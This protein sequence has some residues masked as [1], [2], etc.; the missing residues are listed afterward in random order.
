MVRFFLLK[1]LE[2]A[3]FL[4]ILLIIF[5]IMQLILV[6]FCNIFFFF[7]ILITDQ[8]KLSIFFEIRSF[9]KEKSLITGIRL[10]LF[11]IFFA[12][13]NTILINNGRSFWFTSILY[14]VGVLI[15]QVYTPIAFLFFIK[16]TFWFESLTF[17]ILLDNFVFFKKFVIYAIFADKISFSEN[18]ILYFFGNPWKAPVKKAQS[19]GGAILLGI[20]IGRN[21][22]MEQQKAESMTRDRVAS[23]MGKEATPE[24]RQMMFHAEYKK[25]VHDHCPQLKLQEDLKLLGAR[26]IKGVFE[27]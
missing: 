1:L 14:G 8:K 19:W 24:M 23:F 21:Q 18:Y 13:P 10:L 9:L 25:V 6:V 5:P 17:G 12:I 11:T 22:Q 7:Y 15:F 16:F 3:T 4:E 2:E 20:G 27:P 26:I